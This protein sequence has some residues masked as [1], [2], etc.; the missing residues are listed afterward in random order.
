M[1]VSDKSEYN[2]SI[3][4]GIVVNIDSDDDPDKNAT[5]RVQL[6]IPSMQY[7]YSDKYKKYMTSNNKTTMEDFNVYPWAT[8]LKKDLKVG[9]EIY[10]SFIN[11]DSGKYI[12][13]GQATG[14]STANKTKKLDKDKENN[15]DS[16][17]SGNNDTNNLT[18]SSLLDLIMPII[19]QYEVD[20][21]DLSAWSKNKIPDKCYKSITLHDGVTNCWAIGI[22]QWNG[23][24]AFD[25]MYKCCKA[26]GNKWKDDI[27]SNDDLYKALKAA[28]STAKPASYRG[29]FAK[30]YNPEKGSKLYKGIEK[31][32]T[33]STS[34][35]IQREY[36]KEYTGK[37]VTM[38]QNKGINNPAILIY[39]ADL[40]NQYGTG[41]PETIKVA[42]KA[43]KE[44]NKNYMQQLKLVV[45]KVQTFATYKD[46]ETR[47]KG[48]YKYIKDLYDKGKLTSDLTKKSGKSSSDSPYIGTYRLPTDKLYRVSFKYHQKYKKT[49]KPHRGVDF[50]CTEGTKLYACTDGT[51]DSY[52]SNKGTT[53]AGRSKQDTYWYGHFCVIHANDG[54][55]ILYCHM[56]KTAR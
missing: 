11:N 43:C 4:Y 52:D 55:H 28:I 44:S 14:M 49:G 7:E 21:T 9:D 5:D 1:L 45:K 46:F 51:I 41:L 50:S 13:L 32:L 42:S 17:N 24:D 48:V 25:I 23:V 19:L 26:S 29:G 53:Y 34:K 16:R 38:L 2:S 40:M 27:P 56:K 12:V 3:Y 39:L 6:Y 30:D 47:R 18:N 10:G 22:I 31:V 54:N 15:N 36:A 35:E 33:Y 8:T 20:L 37:T